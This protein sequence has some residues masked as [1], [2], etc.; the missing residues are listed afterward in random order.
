M[1]S[2]LVQVTHPSPPTLPISPQLTATTEVVLLLIGCLGIF[3]G[4]CCFGLVCWFIG[5]KMSGY[6]CRGRR[7]AMTMTRDLQ[8]EEDEKLEGV[9]LERKREREE[10]NRDGDGKRGCGAV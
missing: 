3:L 6:R 1:Q 4:L 7:V 8:R 2:P 5:E 9:C 10:R